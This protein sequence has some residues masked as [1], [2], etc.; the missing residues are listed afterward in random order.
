MKH[1]SFALRHAFKTQNGKFGLFP[2]ISHHN[3]VDIL[4]CEYLLWAKANV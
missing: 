3:I 2:W 4:L 1:G